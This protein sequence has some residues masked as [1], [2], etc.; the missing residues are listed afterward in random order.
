MA[1]TKLKPI[2]KWA[3]GKEQELKYI[4]PKMPKKFNNYF[5]PFVGGG[6]VYFNIGIEHKKFINDKSD[7][8]INIFPELSGVAKAI[9]VKSGDVV[10][11]GQRGYS[12][13]K[14]Y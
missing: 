11:K 1:I 7:E 4:Q 10:K 8:L 9:Y 12:F 3:G 14:A 5:E 2:V 13:R 6:A